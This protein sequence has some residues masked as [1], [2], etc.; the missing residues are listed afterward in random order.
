MHADGEGL[1]NTRIVALCASKIVNVLS[2]VTPKQVSV[3]RSP[4]MI[5]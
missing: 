1:L 4:T 2:E 3:P 5:F